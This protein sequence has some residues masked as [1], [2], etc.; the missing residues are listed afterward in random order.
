MYIRTITLK[1]VIQETV[2]LINKSHIYT[3]FKG[4]YGFFCELQS[5]QL[6]IL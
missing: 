1:G 5:I 2:K 3:F 4:K 6:K